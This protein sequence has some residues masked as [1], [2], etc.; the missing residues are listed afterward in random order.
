MCNF[1]SLDAGV[2][3]RVCR[4]ERLLS[5]YR[6][7][8]IDFTNTSL[9][10]YSIIVKKNTLNKYFLQAFFKLKKLLFIIYYVYCI[11]IDCLDIAGVKFLFFSIAK[12]QQKRKEIRIGVRYHVF[13]D[14]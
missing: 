14:F 4:H 7:L 2:K 10:V 12:R 3:K 1:Y 11:Q 6:V 5:A 13:R 8:G 9:L